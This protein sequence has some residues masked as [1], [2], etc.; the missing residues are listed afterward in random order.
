MAQQLSLV[1]SELNDN[2]ENNTS[3]SDSSDDDD[4]GNILLSL[5]GN[6][7]Q[8][9]DFDLFCLLLDLFTQFYLSSVRLILFEAVLLNGQHCM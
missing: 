3:D 8:K 5:A 7:N 1:E 6:S 2:K 9:W 4:T